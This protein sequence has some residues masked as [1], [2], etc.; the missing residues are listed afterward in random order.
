MCGAAG[1]SLR[2]ESGRRETARGRGGHS[3][4]VSDGAEAEAEATA[5]VQTGGYRIESESTRACTTTHEHCSSTTR[6]KTD[7]GRFSEQHET[8][9]TVKIHATETRI[10]TALKDSENCV[11]DESG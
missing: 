5:T 3:G 4:Q 10:V 11:G 1:V 2:C 9:A 7:N 8:D 6:G